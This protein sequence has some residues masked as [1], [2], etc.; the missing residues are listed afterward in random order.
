MWDFKKYSDNMAMLDES[1]RSVS[2][3]ELEN[4]GKQIYHAE[5]NASDG[6]ADRAYLLL[7]GRAGRREAVLRRCT[8]IFHNP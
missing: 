4:M 1:G 2:Y 5:G 6:A 3:G 7:C 8:C